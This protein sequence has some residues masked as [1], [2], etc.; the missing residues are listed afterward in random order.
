MFG[1][2]MC[3]GN[4]LWCLYSPCVS[5]RQVL[6]YGKDVMDGSRLLWLSLVLHD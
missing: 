6:S 2:C 4:V 5:I 1:P 3:T